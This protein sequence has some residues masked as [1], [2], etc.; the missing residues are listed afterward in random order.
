MYR[1]TVHQETACRFCG[2]LP[3]KCEAQCKHQTQTG[4]LSQRQCRRDATKDGYC[5]RHH[6]DYVPPCNE[7]SVL[8]ALKE[9][10]HDLSRPCRGRV[11]V[12]VGTI[13]CKVYSFRYR[14]GDGHALT[15]VGRLVS[16]I[17][18]PYGEHSFVFESARY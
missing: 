8:D 10:G 6:P 2:E 16:A 3:C 1:G 12:R 14:V 17:R 9:M 11:V 4:I 7:V 18:M 5:T 15:R 13:R